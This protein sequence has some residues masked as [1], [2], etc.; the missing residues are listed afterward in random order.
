[1]GDL[2][3]ENWEDLMST[4]QSNYQLKEQ[5]KT[6]LISLFHSL[7]KALE[8]KCA[9]HW[10]IQSFERY[11]QENI[12]PIGL[13]IQIFPMVD[14]ISDN[15]KKNWESKLNDCSRNLMMLLQDEY[16]L[17]LNNLDTEIDALY[18]RLTPLKTHE[19][20]LTLEE[21]LREHL[22]TSSKVILQKKD[23]KFWRDKNA[24]RENRAYRWHQNKDFRN[25]TTKKSSK[26]K[27][28]KSDYS[29][30]T[31]SNASSSA[32]SLTDRFVRKRKGLFAKT[33][34]M[35]GELQ[36]IH[37]KKNIDTPHTLRGSKGETTSRPMENSK[38]SSSGKSKA[39]KITKDLGAIPKNQTQ[40]DTFLD[41]MT[42]TQ[43]LA[44]HK[45]QVSTPTPSV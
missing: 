20:Y 24:F 31:N 23:K 5:V 8:K 45:E 38:T 35:E 17:Q 1:M 32:S 26:N 4:I 43:A 3:G 41:K 22:K 12:N 16:R 18:A 9:L 11:I 27:G 34:E 28:E 33:Q 10:H 21:K 13:R 42:L 14:H 30:D 6:D 2:L 15:L 44:T 19:D 39:I 37:K 7:T 36:Q 25:K 29:S 40:L